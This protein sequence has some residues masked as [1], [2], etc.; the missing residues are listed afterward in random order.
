VLAAA[1]AHA[2]RAQRALER[3]DPD[4]RRR[5]ADTH[6][7]LAEDYPPEQVLLQRAYQ[8]IGEPKSNLTPE[9]QVAAGAHLRGWIRGNKDILDAIGPESHETIAAVRANIAGT[10]GDSYLTSAYQRKATLSSALIGDGMSPGRARAL[11]SVMMESELQRHFPN[12][13]PDNIRAFQAEVKS[14]EPRRSLAGL[15]TFVQEFKNTVFAIDLGIFG[16]QGSAG[17][18]HGIAPI[19]V[20]S[21]NRAFAL[22]HL[23]HAGM[24]LADSGMGFRAQA[25]IDGL[26]FYSRLDPAGSVVSTSSGSLFQHLG[27]PG[28]WFDEKL[29]S[30]TSEV[31]NHLQFG[32]IMDWGRLLVYEGNLTMLHATGRDV[33]NAAVR[34]TAARNANAIGSVA[35]IALRPN[36]A[37]T[38]ATMLLSPQMTR[39]QLSLVGQVARGFSPR[40]TAAEKLIAAQTIISFTA[41]S[42]LFGKALHSQFGVGDFEMD[43]FKP[44][45]GFLTFENGYTVNMFSQEQFKDALMQSFQA[46]NDGDP[47]V[48]ARAWARFGMGRLSP[49][50]S[51]VI[52]GLFGYGYQQGL[53]YR[54]GDLT[55]RGALINVLPVPPMVS[56]LMTGDH[57]AF[58]LGGEGLGFN[59][60]PE[61]AYAIADRTSQEDPQFGVPYKDLP[62]GGTI[63]ENNQPRNDGRDDFEKKYPEIAAAL[64]ENTRARADAGDVTAEGYVAMETI[65]NQRRDDE[66]AAAD[67]FRETGDRDGFGEM[68]DDIQLSTAVARGQVDTLYQLYKDSGDLP[69]DPNERARVEY[70]DSFDPYRLPGG[71]L[72]G[73]GWSEAYAKLWQSWDDTQRA[74]VEANTGLMEHEDPDVEAYYETKRGLSEE[75]GWYSITD[76]AWSQVSPYYQE[77]ASFETMG[78]YQDWYIA[79]GTEYYREGY[80]VDAM[81]EAMRQMNR[82]KAYRQFVEFRSEVRSKWIAGNRP[83]ADEAIKYGLIGTNVELRKWRILQREWER[84]YGQ[85]Q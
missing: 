2:I 68:L 72:D 54:Y 28:R 75:N 36:R 46:L 9:Q 65:D 19:F 76:Y 29:W 47:E 62:P 50:A 71:G 69:E 17:F 78:E 39:A 23:P 37:A 66:L 84:S 13:V 81:D 55:R 24:L 11:S 4:Y 44:G 40:A 42:L 41:S 51:V 5:A 33:T 45:F 61:G 6:R 70:Y 10:L 43:P 26:K 16:V 59:I 56:Q 31:L 48:A 57:S 34:R 14:V 80:G 85:N 8:M 60:F 38:E 83:L 12:G 15:A 18:A 52:G 63:D 20:G 53:G 30:P 82:V 74:Y 3:L 21:I 27:A 64:D 77:L 1:R 35:D 22:L 73:E 58:A 79:E 49:V 7:V 32:T 67:I 25:A